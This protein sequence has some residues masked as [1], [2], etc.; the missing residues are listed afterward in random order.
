M[1][2]FS[3][4]RLK[5][6]NIMSQITTEEVKHVAGLA[7]LEFAESEI[8]GF[9]DTLGKIIDMVEMLNEVD[10]EGVAFTMNVADNDSRMRDDVAV[11]GF[12]REKLLEN[13][14]TH[15]NGFI[16]VPAMLTD[17]GDA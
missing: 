11:E 4:K 12:D 2:A 13:V 17:G 10:T 7:K 14:P 6:Q 1:G 15:E 3:K 5:G 16:K 9:T 8:S